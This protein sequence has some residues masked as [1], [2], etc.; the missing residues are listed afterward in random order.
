[1]LNTLIGYCLIFKR[2]GTTNAQSTL[3]IRG[4]GI[5]LGHIWCQISAHS[6]L[7]NEQTLPK[8][9]YIIPNFLVLYFG[10]NFMKI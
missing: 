7:K 5:F 2:S 6:Q 8:M 4:S 3:D 1:M 9:V 10:E